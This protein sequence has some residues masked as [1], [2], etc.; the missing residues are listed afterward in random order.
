MEALDLLASGR[1]CHSRASEEALGF[2]SGLQL[3]CQPPRAWAGNK[4][5]AEAAWSG[6]RLGVSLWCKSK[7][8]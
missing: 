7:P 4:A 6:L 8:V 2:Q 5:R 3:S 1:Q